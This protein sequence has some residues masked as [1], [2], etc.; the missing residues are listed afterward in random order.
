M[1][2]NIV[3]WQPNNRDTPREVPPEVFV[4]EMLGVSSIKDERVETY[5][6]GAGARLIPVL[7]DVRDVAEWLE[8][9]ELE[10]LALKIIR[11]REEVCQ[12]D[13][14]DVLFLKEMV[15]EPK[16]YAR[17]Y[18]LV[19]HPIG[20][21]TSKLFAIVFYWTRCYYLSQQQLALLM[22]HELLHIPELGDMLVD[23]DVKEFRS[24]LK[25]LNIDS[26]WTKPGR[27]VPDILG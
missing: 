10:Q 6:P 8:A 3:I 20:F 22:F 19:G 18:R 15:T 23:H 1:F 26:N 17:T 16:A 21:F 14:D 12:V 7:L 4:F 13:V 5:M 2:F 24:V 11:K 9:K 27:E 25:V